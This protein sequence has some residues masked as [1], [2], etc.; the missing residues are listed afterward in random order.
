MNHM[1]GKVVLDTNIIIGHFRDE[2]RYLERLARVEYFIPHTVLG[3]LYSGAYRSAR[4]AK[5]I[6]KL[7]S[8]LSN[9][10][11][12]SND[13]DTDLIYGK[14]WAELASIGKPIPTNDIWIAAT[15]LQYNLP[16]VTADAHFSHINGLETL[17]W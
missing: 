12:L 5:H 4:P 3:E 1:S 16:L 13:L 14:I 7:R 11:V 6:G 9:G 15:A 10:K 8:F 2:E 17:H